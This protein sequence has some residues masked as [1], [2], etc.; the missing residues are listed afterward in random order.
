MKYLFLILISF[1]AFAGEW[2]NVSGVKYHNSCLKNFGKEFPKFFKSSIGQGLK[3]LADLKSPGSD[4]NLKRLQKLLGT[5][6]LRIGCHEKNYH[7]D[8]AIAH[9]SVDTSRNLPKL[10][11]IHPYISIDPKAT[12]KN[13]GKKFM[14]Q[15]LFHELIH[16]IGYLHQYTVDYAYACEECCFSTG[17]VKEHACKVCKSDYTG[18]SDENYISDLSYYYD[19]SSWGR[20]INFPVVV[21]RALVENYNSLSN[22]QHLLYYDQD[23]ALSYESSQQWLRNFTSSYLE[24]IVSQGLP[25]NENDFTKLARD[26]FDARDALFQGDFQ[27]AYDLYVNLNVDNFTSYF[28]VDH[29]RASHMWDTI[30]YDLDALYTYKLS[31]DQEVELDKKYDQ[32]LKAKPK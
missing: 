2:A 17:K 22:I 1:S 32:I 9:A 3:C 25:E 11:L 28:L 26:S 23:S 20:G 24:K 15:V 5:N 30:L 31:K 29:K 6:S 16:D 8:K 7:W 4:K 13:Q 19:E 27:K 12:F 10:G 21:R 18:L 14:T